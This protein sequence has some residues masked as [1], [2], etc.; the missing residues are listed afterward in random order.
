VLF[1][2]QLVE[3]GAADVVFTPPFHPYTYGLLLSVPGAVGAPS[4][5]PAPKQTSGGAARSGH[6]CV[7]AGRC[8]WQLGSDCETI[9]PP[10]R[11]TDDGLAI[12]CHIPLDELTARAG[13]ASKTGRGEPPSSA[14][15]P[16]AAGLPG[17]NGANA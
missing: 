10:W 14:A 2:G 7:Y 12:R 13:F 5:A 17:S 11:Q 15:G 9:D 1:H 16:T 4:D 3:N 6:G 8:P